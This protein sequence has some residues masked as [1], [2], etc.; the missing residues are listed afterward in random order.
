MIQRIQSLY[1]F[2]SAV[3]A[4]G[5]VFLFKKEVNFDVRLA[6]SAIS[7][8]LAIIAIASF[9]KRRVQIKINYFN[10]IINL[11]LMVFM[12]LHLLKTSGEGTLLSK[13]GVELLIPVVIIILL[14]MANKH[15][16]RDD[17][18]VKSVD[19]FR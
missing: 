12:V 5:L 17:K 19:R 14:F 18:L 1:L 8:F 7:G 13:K 3:F 4:F 16:G 6:L 15:I 10:I 11:V 9:K 2:L